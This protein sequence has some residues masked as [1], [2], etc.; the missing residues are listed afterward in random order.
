MKVHRLTDLELVEKTQCASTTLKN[1]LA[2]PNQ[3]NGYLIIRAF[4][5]DVT[6]EKGFNNPGSLPYKISGNLTTCMV[7]H[8]GG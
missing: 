1:I 2:S 7:Q 6:K 3:S 5:T 8:V 4:F